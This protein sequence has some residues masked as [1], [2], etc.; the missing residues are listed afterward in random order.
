METGNTEIHGDRKYRDTW[1]QELLRYMKRQE[2]QRYMET[3]NEIQKYT[4]T[5]NT[6]IYGDKK[7]RIP[8]RQEIKRYM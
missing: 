1:R 7:Y 5:G 3:G 6:E 4:E 2:I 8:W